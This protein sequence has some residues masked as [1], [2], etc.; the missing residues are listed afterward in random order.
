[1]IDCQFIFTTYKTSLL[2]SRKNVSPNFLHLLLEETY[3]NLAREFIPSRIG[4]MQI[5][6]IQNTGKKFFGHHINSTYYFWNRCLLVYRCELKFSWIKLR[7]C[8]LINY[9][10]VLHSLLK[11]DK[12][13][14]I[15]WATYPFTRISLADTVELKWF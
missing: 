15:F 4:W 3:R 2:S 9:S 11:L 12:S 8:C 5:H 13:F 1:M 14:A 6:V 7:F 10:N